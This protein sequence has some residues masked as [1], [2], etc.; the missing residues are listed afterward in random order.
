MKGKLTNQSTNYSSGIELATFR[1]VAQYSTECPLIRALFKRTNISIGLDIAG[2][3]NWV[4]WIQTKIHH[5]VVTKWNFVQN[6]TLSTVS[7]FPGQVT[8]KCNPNWICTLH[9]SCFHILY[10]VSWLT[11]WPWRWQ[12]CVFWNICV[13]LKTTLFCNAKDAPFHSSW[14]NNICNAIVVSA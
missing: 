5:S 4:L 3:G 12:W 2:T 1:F 7:Y 13:T 10:Y 8:V 11:F 9:V 14:K 6:T